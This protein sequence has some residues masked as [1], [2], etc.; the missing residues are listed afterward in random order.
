MAG[1]TPE[2]ETTDLPPATPGAAPPARAGVVLRRLL[3]SPAGL[4]GAALTCLV[5]LVALLADRIVSGDP[6]SSAGASL[7]PPSGGH[8]MGTDNFGRDIL[9]AVVHG[10]R[11]SMTVVLWVVVISLA[12][13]LLVG[14]LSG[15]RGGWVDDV[16]MRVTEMF[17]SI[18]LFFLAL[19][20]VAFFGAG[21]DRLILVL[22]VMS[23]ELPA[24]VVRAESLSMRRR[25]FVEAARSLGATD[26]MILFRH[27][28]PN[29]F[30]A[31]L[32]V[33]SL[34]GSRVILIEAALSFIG[35]GDPNSI[36]LGYLLNNA[37]G[38]LQVAW[39]MSVFPGAGIAVAVLGLNLLSDA[40]ND[41]LDPR[42]AAGRQRR[43]RFEDPTRLPTRSRTHAGLAVPPEAGTVDLQ[44][45]GR[46]E[47][48]G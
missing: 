16:L 17:Q 33:V 5:T 1:S 11:T 34:I 29:V 38:F 36:S 43:R 23:W 40:L 44:S 35:L 27:L 30:P 48:R 42:V 8:L 2:S 4:V 26:R 18:P 31:A 25:E 3:R 15:Y 9:R 45:S 7:R 32:V 46:T 14:M 28:L 47:R 19:L 6:F 22:G 21:L 37:Q 24:R 41:V 12:V 20:V 13:G 10:M 39:W